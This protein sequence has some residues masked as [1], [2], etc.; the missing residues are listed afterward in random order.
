MTMSWATQLPLWAD[1]AVFSVVAVLGSY[2]IGQFITRVVCRRLATMA[3][4]TSWQWDEILI[5]GIRTGI[6]FWSLLLG[7]YLAF[8]FWHLPE[9]LSHAL[10]SA[11]FVLIALSA[12]FLL[13]GI[14]SQLIVLYGS[15][16]QQAMPVTSLTQNIARLIIVAIGLLMILNGLGISIAPLLTALG[17]GGL[18]VALALQDTLSN[19]FA[20][21]YVTMSRQ[22]QTGDYVKMESGEEG[23]VTDIGWRA[24]KIRMLPNNMV[25]VPNKKLGEA[26]ITNYDLPS[27]D[28]AVTVEVGVAYDS[29]LEQVERVTCEV[30][31]EVMQSVAGAVPTFEPFIRFHSFGDYSVNFTVISPAGSKVLNN[32]NGSVVGNFWNVTWGAF[33]RVS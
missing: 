30:G 14:V 18:A 23:Y 28:L 7:V 10:T 13:A 15:T 25:L 4:Q 3:K 2:L 6:P 24:T 26:I 1:E 20:G 33:C 29:D 27:Q 9:H 11:L 22:I 16:I 17:V 32:V 5:E 31:R 12:T 8:G 19:L 21:F